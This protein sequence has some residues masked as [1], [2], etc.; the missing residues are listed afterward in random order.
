MR[1]DS[2][3][4]ARAGFGKRRADLEAELVEVRLLASGD[5]LAARLAL[6]LLGA[7]GNVDRHLHLD[8]RVE[9]HRDGVQAERLYRRVE[10]HLL[11]VQG[12]AAGRHGPGEVAG[13]DR[14]VEHAGLA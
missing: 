5:G 14:A 4:G 7:A 13:R 1:T 12:E 9:A 3:L 6:G 8:L 11:A 10:R 2:S